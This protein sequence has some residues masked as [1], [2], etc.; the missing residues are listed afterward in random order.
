[1]ELLTQSLDLIVQA[2]GTTL[3][4][5]I[6][7]GIGSIVLGVAVGIA[8]IGPIPVLRLGAFGYT[9]F[10]LNVPLLVVLV[11]AVF[12][13]PYIGIIFDLTLTAIIVLIVYEAAYIAETV[14]SGI[15]T[16][17]PGQVEA[18]RALGLSFP[19]TLRTLVIPQALAAVTQPIGN[20]MIALL[21]N[22]SFVAIFGVVEITAQT[23]KLNEMLAQPI[24]LYTGAG[25]VYMFMALLIGAGAA[26]LEKKL[27][28]QR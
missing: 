22:S 12:G 19:Q 7:S 2:I 13:L 3:L 8:R 16:I 14:R 20:V 1:M 28:F 21:M 6:V 24:L 15:N 10:F 4:I 25:L 17:S 27:V 18:A 23:R 11:F 26:A 5:V 9:Q